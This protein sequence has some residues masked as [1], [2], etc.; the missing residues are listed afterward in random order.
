MTGGAAAVL[1]AVVRRARPWPALWLALA[2]WPAAAPAVSGD[3]GHIEGYAAAVLERE[4]GLPAPSLRVQHGVI[5]LDAAELAGAD[6]ERVVAA[7]ERIRGVV[8][9]EVREPG[10]PDTGPPPSARPAAPPTVLK[11]YQVG[12]LPGGQLFD[13]LIADPRW[14]HFAAAYQSFIGDPQLRNVASVSFGETFALYRDRLAGAWW[15]VGVQA[16]VFALFDLDAESKDLVNADY[17]VGIPLAARSQ[18]LSALLRLFHLSSHLGDEFILRSRVRN[19]VNLSYESV[20]LKLSYDAGDVLRIYGGG[21]YLFDQEPAS[22]HPWSAQLG[23]ELRSPW[24]AAGTRWRPVAGLDL[25]SR[26]ENDWAID[27]SLRAGLQIEGVLATRNLQL[28]LEYFNGHSPNG[29][30]FKQE[31]EYIGFGAHFHF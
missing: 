16:G 13:P 24:P 27:L 8:R 26:E 9:V 4:F 17:F 3:D 25:Q 30:F 18:D 23:V 11:E 20:D 28:V 10:A 6:R 31:L 29:Q 2:L 7:L 12:V 19:R 5:T 22:L 15:E 1:R 14:P 21:G